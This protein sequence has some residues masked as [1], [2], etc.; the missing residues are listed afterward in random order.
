MIGLDWQRLTTFLNKEQINTE[1]WQCQKHISDSMLESLVNFWS[2][3]E[4][5]LTSHS[6]VSN[7][8]LCP[9]MKLI[10]SLT[11]R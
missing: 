8:A 11:G 1:R 6:L 10:V 5:S 9:A 7:Q 3:G 2:C 4:Q